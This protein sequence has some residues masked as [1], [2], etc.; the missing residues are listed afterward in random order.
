MAVSTYA[1]PV[2]VGL[3]TDAPD[4]LADYNIGDAA[5]AATT[6]AGYGIT[7]AYTMTETDGLL[8]DKSD[9]GHL[10]D[11]RYY[12]EDEVD[13]LLSGYS[14]SG[15]VHAAGDI[16][17]GTLAIARGGTNAGT[18]ADARTN[19][20]L[21]TA[22]TQASSAFAA[23]SHT[24]TTADIS[25]G[26]S[27]G[28]AVV[29]GDTQTANA[30]FA[31]PTTGS[32]AAPTFRA[33][34]AADLPTITVLGTVVTGVWTGTTIAVANG[35]TGA[36]DASGARTNLGLVIGTNVQAYDAELA[37][38]AGLTSGADLGIYFTGSGTAGTFTLTSAARTVLDDA[39]VA[40]M[41]DTLGGASSTGTGGL[42]RATSP[43]FVT[44]ILGTPTSGTLTN[45]TGLPLSGV[46]I[47]GATE[48]TAPQPLADYIATYDASAAANKKTLLM[49]ADPGANM[50]RVF[51]V[52]DDFMAVTAPMGVSTSVSGTG[53]GISNSG[54]FAAANVIGVV[55][56]STGTTTTGRCSLLGF[57]LSVVF[58]T[59][60]WHF[61]ALVGTDPTGDA[62]ND[63]TLRAGFLDS[64]SA[65]STDGHFF[66]Q[67]YNVNS[68][69]WQA[70]TRSNGSETATDTGVAFADYTMYRMD[71]DV[72]A[73]GLSAVF[74][75]NG[76]TVATHTSASVSMP[77]GT[78]RAAGYG[79][80]IQKEAGGTA[81]N[82]YVDYY[83]V[84][85]GPLSRS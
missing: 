82:L 53:A 13:D 70:V 83:S 10:H 61:E 52:W 43:T 16:T 23:A 62:T 66:R 56:L 28:K 6:L 39:T 74:K 21:G 42:A 71:I 22:A 75:I 14:A 26:T 7:D 77:T 37:A 36:T 58:G 38:I 80:Y 63:Y 64:A 60:P 3:R 84:W 18:A 85:S 68:G 55:A 72:A 11:G 59:N 78:S 4:S 32:P 2:F 9:L 57:T 33:L 15:H 73:D 49:R 30:V 47:T 25:D 79:F 5:A 8:A 51:H 29:K 46:S 44:P 54:T 35:G 67:N 40:A 1:W 41:V 19:L 17:S 65:E 34:V 45:C 50:Q 48:D 12:T 24:H 31:G 27:T 69:K 81:R 76:S 20:G